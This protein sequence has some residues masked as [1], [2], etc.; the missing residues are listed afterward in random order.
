MAMFNRIDE[1]TRFVD[2]LRIL[3]MRAGL[4]FDLLAKEIGALDQPDQIAANIRQVVDSLPLST[5]LP[6]PQIGGF[7][8]L[9]TV[10]EIRD[11]AKKWQNCLA[12]YL[13]NVNDGSAAIYL[14]EPLEAVCAVGRQGRIGWVLLQAKGPRNIDIDPDQLAEI[15]ATFSNAGIPPSSMI[16]AIKAIL[17]NYQWSRRRQLPEDEEIFDDIP[18]Y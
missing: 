17:Q 2:G 15:Y 7:R 5:T 18:L 3:A 8:R 16:E 14:A 13:Y 6:P 12:G 1:M 10:A 9:D 11:L 4:S